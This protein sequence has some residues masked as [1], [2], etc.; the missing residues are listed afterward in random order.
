[1]F[2]K[3]NHQK[4]EVYTYSRSLTLACYKLTKALPAEER[5]G[6]ISQIRRAALSVHLNIAE[7]ASKKSEVERRRY[8]EISRGSI[9]EVDAALDIAND[10]QY[11]NN[12]DMKDLEEKMIKTFK[13]LTGLILS[14]SK[15]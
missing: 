11:L 10:L 9:V 14:C 2:L 5:F 7:G 13:L 6:M 1:M 8:Y 12:I 4:L 15:H 3:L